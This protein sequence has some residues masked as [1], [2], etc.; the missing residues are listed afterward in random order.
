MYTNILVIATKQ[1]YKLRDNIMAGLCVSGT[2][3]E[4]CDRDNI[5]GYELCDRDSVT[6]YD[7]LRQLHRFI[8]TSTQCFL[9]KNIG[10]N[11]RAI[12]SQFLL[13]DAS[14]GK[15]TV[16]SPFLPVGL[17]EEIRG[18]NY[19]NIAY[20]RDVCNDLI[21]TVPTD[22]QDKLYHIEY[23]FRFLNLYPINR[24]PE[25]SERYESYERLV[26]VILGRCDYMRKDCDCFMRKSKVEDDPEYYRLLCVYRDR[27]FREIDETVIIYNDIMADIQRKKGL[28]E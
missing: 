23:V 24:F 11:E 1:S 2:G 6:G 9:K 12:I 22:K 17:G 21:K 27:M 3:Y 19:M 20:F 18:Q 5:T 25:Y 4:L 16:C 10:R 13:G 26:S 28:V 15:S 14:T 7:R 8:D